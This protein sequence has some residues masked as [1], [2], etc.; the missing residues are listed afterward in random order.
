M[1][2]IVGVQLA[3]YSAIITLGLNLG[4]CASVV[5]ETVKALYGDSA[6]TKDAVQAA[7]IGMRSYKGVLVQINDYGDWPQKGTAAC[8]KMKTTLLCRDQATWE[9]LQDAIRTASPIVHKA[10]LVIDGVAEDDTGTALSS[11]AEAMEKTES[12]F[13][14][15]AI[16]NPGVKP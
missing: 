13:L 3:A 12:V 7:A 11:A 4:G 14:S 2:T 16:P 1:R 10:R 9:R 8:T 6:Y 15:S 5:Q